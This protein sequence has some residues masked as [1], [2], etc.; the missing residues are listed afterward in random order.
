MDER[1]LAGRMRSV[2]HNLR[3]SVLSPRLVAL[4]VKVLEPLVARVLLEEVCHRS[5]L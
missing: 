5:G 1:S 3:Y 4:F 2:T